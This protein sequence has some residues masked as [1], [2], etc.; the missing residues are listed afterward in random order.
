VVDLHDQYIADL[1]LLELILSLYE[2]YGARLAVTIQ[3]YF[4]RFR[5]INAP[6]IRI[7]C[8]SGWNKAL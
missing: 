7:V 3:F 2:G 4:F 6:Y 5:H 8:V 1:E